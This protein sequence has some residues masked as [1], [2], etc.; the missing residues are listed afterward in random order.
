MVVLGTKPEYFN[1]V[2]VKNEWSRYLALIKQGHKKMLIPAYKGMDAYDLPEEFSHLQAQD[3]SRLG[4]MQDLIRGVKKIVGSNVSKADTVNVTADAPISDSFTNTNIAPL[5]ERTFLFLEDGDFESANEY[6]EK[7]LDLDPKCARAYLAK[8]MVD[9]K[10]KH[11]EDLRNCPEPFS[12]NGN[13]QKVLR[14]GD[15]N[16]KKEL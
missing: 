7:V 1:A 6:A 12:N 11:K 2:W 15:S 4:F 5:L 13:Y 14:F 3:M 8:L 16:L 9:L 10:S